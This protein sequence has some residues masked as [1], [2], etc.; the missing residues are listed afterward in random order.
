M[1][2]LVLDPAVALAGILLDDLCQCGSS[3]VEAVVIA[4]T[5][6]GFSTGL[7]PCGLCQNWLACVAPTSLTGH[8]S[9]V[10][11][12]S[13]GY[14]WLS[15]VMVTG[16]SFARFH[17]NWIGLLWPTPVW[18]WRDP[19]RYIVIHLDMSIVAARWPR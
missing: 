15:D 11:P 6:F 4:S 7:P 12:P 17:S 1:V 19:Q 8:H 13:P 18:I 16:T 10:A 14:P 9:G 2:L 5:V 3:I